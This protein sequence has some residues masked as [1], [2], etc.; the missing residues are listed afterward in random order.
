MYISFHGPRP[1]NMRTC[2]IFSSTRSQLFEKWIEMAV[3][4]QANRALFINEQK[5]LLCTVEN[6]Y[7][8]GLQ[9]TTA[10]SAWK[11]AEKENNFRDYWLTASFVSERREMAVYVYAVGLCQGK[12]K[13]LL[14]QCERSYRFLQVLF[15]A[16]SIT[17]LALCGQV[18]FA[19]WQCNEFFSIVVI[20][21]AQRY[22]IN[23]DLSL[24]KM[25]ALDLNASRS[26]LYR[27][28]SN[29]GL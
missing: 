10:A 19:R 26:I 3:R 28:S 20:A 11:K 9:S 8:C 16:A 29:T 7:T 2:L 23:F 12:F 25:S 14:L 15:C 27:N 18:L 5:N 24:E 21:E 6:K 1:N 4:E 17:L 22:S 13:C